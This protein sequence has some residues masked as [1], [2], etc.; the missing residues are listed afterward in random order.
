MK[1]SLSMTKQI[2]LSL[3]LALTLFLSAC[4]KRPPEGPRAP[5]VPHSRPPLLHPEIADT[6]ERKAADDLIETGV[7]ALEEEN[8]AK[9]EWSFREAIRIAPSYGAPYYWLA[10]VK[11]QLDETKRAWD[12]LDRAQLLIGHDKKWKE[13]IETLRAAITEANP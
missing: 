7:A 1:W 6:P 11:Y 5:E 10:L 4:P 8:Y 9:G 2:S 3:L 13:R 12:L